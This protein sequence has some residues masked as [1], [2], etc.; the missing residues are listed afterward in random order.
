MF[1]EVY[2][3]L[4]QCEATGHD[5]QKFRQFRGS[6]V[7]RTRD[8]NPLLISLNNA[9]IIRSK[10][11]LMSWYRVKYTSNICWIHFFYAECVLQTVKLKSIV[12]VDIIQKYDFLTETKPTKFN[13]NL[14]TLENTPTHTW[15]ASHACKILFVDI[16]LLWK[17]RLQKYP[18]WDF[19]RESLF[20]IKLWS[21]NIGIRNYLRNDK[22]F[23]LE[24]LENVP[25]GSTTF[26][27]Y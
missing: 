26:L 10:T 11:H 17:Y 4:N 7:S 22:R 23:F 1:G 5:E 9:F 12:E 24:M 18:L 8:W 25:R 3:I 21:V 13:N 16:T 2:G 6:R 27:W 14:R 20:M 19:Q 15:S